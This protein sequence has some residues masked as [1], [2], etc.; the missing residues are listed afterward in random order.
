MAYIRS[1]TGGSSNLKSNP[2]IFLASCNPGNVGGSAGMRNTKTFDSID[3]DLFEQTDNGIAAKKA[4]HIYIT[5]IGSNYCRG[6]IYKNETALFSERTIVDGNIWELDLNQGDCIYVRTGS[7]DSSQG[8]QFMTF[9]VYG[10]YNDL[11]KL[12]G[13]NR[14]VLYSYYNAGTNTALATYTAW[15]RKSLYNE[16]AIREYTANKLINVDLSTGRITVT[17][18]CTLNLIRYAYPFQGAVIYKNSTALHNGTI[19]T[20]T[21]PMIIEMT[22]SDYILIQGR[23]ADQHYS[24]NACCYI[25]Y[26]QK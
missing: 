22:P 4:M 25:I 16:S 3:T 24:A 5:L 9:V 20:S 21:D 10:Y 19:T 11:K 6:T 1:G 8:M 17:K 13:K 23:C 14:E 15:R 26:E 18:N 2:P 12:G 7:A